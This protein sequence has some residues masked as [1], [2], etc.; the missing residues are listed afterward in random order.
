[1]FNYALT[2]IGHYIFTF[3]LKSMVEIYLGYN[4]LVEAILGRDKMHIPSRT[5]L[6]KTSKNPQSSALF[7][8]KN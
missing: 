7:G 2:K 8:P 1:M 3:T 5:E 4:L 6:C